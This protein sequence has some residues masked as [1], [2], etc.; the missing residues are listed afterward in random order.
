MAK[1]FNEVTADHF[2]T[3][4]RDAPPHVQIEAHL[5]E[6]GGGG[7]EGIKYKLQVLKN[8]GWKYHELISFGAHAEDAAMAFN[9]IRT[10]LL[11]TEERDEVL[12]KLTALVA[13]EA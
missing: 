4:S 2:L 8:A 13:G 1:E 7:K 5:I 6:I 10:V 12:N 11:K 3:F 9:H